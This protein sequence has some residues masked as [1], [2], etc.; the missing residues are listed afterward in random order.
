VS[1]VSRVLNL[2]RNRQAV[3]QF[4]DRRLPPEILAR[5]LECAR[6]APSAREDQPWRFI[7]VQ[8]ALMLHRIARAV[9][10]G[11]LIRT[12][13]ALVI[14][15]ARVHSNIAGSGRPSHPVDLAAATQ[16]MALAAADMSLGTAWITGFREGEIREILGIPAD[17]PV[18]TLLAIGYP[19]GFQRLPRRRPDEEIIAWD[20]WDATS[21]GAEL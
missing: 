3:K 2:S 21:G 14:G 9:F 10:Q 18:V 12:A 8:D 17:V 7:V 16:A 1:A 19:D 6:Y 15:C 20:R 11:D 4:A 5:V 13:P